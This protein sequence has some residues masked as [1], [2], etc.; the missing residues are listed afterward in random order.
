MATVSSKR[1]SPVAARKSKSSPARVPA[2]APARPAVSAK[3]AGRAPKSGNTTKAAAA[4]APW[5]E[6]LAA[7][8]RVETLL[9]SA[10]VRGKAGEDDVDALRR[11]LSDAIERRGEAVM[12]R[13]AAMLGRTRAGNVVPDELRSELDSLLVEMGAIRFEASPMDYFD[14][15]I[16]SP[17]EEVPRADVPAGTIV[18]SLLPGFRS[19]RGAVLAKAVVAVAGRA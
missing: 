9:T 18:A 14:P 1:K 7:V 11:V 10:P 5:A 19:A 4:P 16:H 2:K 13:L 17:A 12:K 15:L 6:I 8:Q 3:Q